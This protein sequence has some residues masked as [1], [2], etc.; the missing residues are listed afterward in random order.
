MHNAFCK[1]KN[2]YGQDVEDFAL[3]LFGLFKVSAGRR[4]DFK[5]IQVNMNLNE[6]LFIKH[7]QVRWLSIGPALQRII[8]QWQAI[9]AY[10]AQLEKDPKTVPKSVNFKLIRDAIHKPDMKFKIIFLLSVIP[11]FEE[12]LREFQSEQPLIHILYTRMSSF[13]ITLRK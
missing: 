4:E 1:G 6:E 11:L 2:E 9:C 3:S 10:V 5:Q 8:D 12:F 13:L 7:S